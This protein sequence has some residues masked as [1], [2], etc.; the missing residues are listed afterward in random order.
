MANQQ[1]FEGQDLASVLERVREVHGEDARIVAAN[2]LRK[3]GV[4]GF[5]ARELF[6][7]IVEFDGT[8]GPEN[9]VASAAMAALAPERERQ[10]GLDTDAGGHPILDLAEAVSEVEKERAALR[11]AGRALAREI[12]DRRRLAPR[13]EPLGF[14][15][16]D[17]F[18]APAAS[19]AASAPA[20]APVST[21]SAQFAS[22]LARI[23]DGVDGPPAT[24][25]PPAA[26]ASPAAA[27]YAELVEDEVAEAI[28]VND[29]T[30]EVWIGDDGTFTTVQP[31]APPRLTRVAGDVPREERPAV[32][33]ADEVMAAEPP[34][35]APVA[36][37][38]AAPVAAAPTVDPGVALTTAVAEYP[39]AATA[40]D[41]APSA[42][43]IEP[44]QI[45]PFG[46]E[47]TA[48]LRTESASRRSVGR[49][50]GAAATEAPDTI[51]R[52]EFK[53]VDLGVPTRMVPR[54]VRREDL[55]VALADS[56]AAHL[57]TVPELPQA[58]GVV[59]AAVGIGR[60]AIDLGRSLAVEL[61]L[62]HEEVV[63]AI[64]DPPFGTPDW[65]VIPDAAC[66]AERRQSWQRRSTATVVS[67]VVDPERGAPN[68]WKWAR[69]ILD[70]LEPTRAWLIADA[71]S[72]SADI[73]ARIDMLGGVDLLALEHLEDTVSPA[74]ALDLG[75]PIG[76]IGGQV[77]TP[78]MW[79]HLLVR[80]LAH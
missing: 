54:G 14:D 63:V 51:E 77:A 8:A 39:S 50:D 19:A 59:I 17:D 24:A 16:L 36:A 40:V 31:F 53:L 12:D 78:A 23:A 79:S 27:A 56:L 75:L 2:R 74:S 20:P 69:E 70:H 57:P 68:G 3:G 1:R 61:S 32:M 42:T 72:K 35:P 4:G 49:R 52:P 45:D 76:R 44:A 41:A 33:R 43:P 30:S 37:S 65:L 15:D 11:A 62:D 18:I 7:V 73:T 22:I 9:M 80:R 46:A 66:A 6:E 38:V 64:P 34:A 58:R 10:F 26:A 47:L 25:M 55:E 21:E 60:E 13:V 48:A 67:V 29:D 28:I 71:R 5:F